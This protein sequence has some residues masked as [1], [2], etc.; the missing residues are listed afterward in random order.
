M[1]SD[2]IDHPY[3]VVTAFGA[4]NTLSDR[5]LKART[6]MRPRETCDETQFYLLCSEGALWAPRYGRPVDHNFPLSL[7]SV[8]A[9]RGQIAMRVWLV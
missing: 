1:A 9:V 4:M 2:A 8:C 7:R 3:Y 5:D 6:Q